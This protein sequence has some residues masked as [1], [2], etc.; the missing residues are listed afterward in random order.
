MVLIPVASLHGQ[1]AIPAD[2]QTNRRER[3]DP[4]ATGMEQ[5]TYQQNSIAHC[6]QHSQMVAGKA[7]HRAG[8]PPDAAGQPENQLCH[9]GQRHCQNSGNSG[10]NAMEQRREKSAGK[11]NGNQPQHQQIGQR[12]I[13]GDKAEMDC[14]QGRGKQR[15]ANGSGQRS[16]DKFS[17]GRAQPVQS[18]AP[19]PQKCIAG[20]RSKQQS[21]HRG[22][23]E[24]QAHRT[25]R[26][27]IDQQQAHQRSQQRRGRVIF[28][29]DN[30]RQQQNRLHG[31]GANHRRRQAGHHGKERNGQYAEQTAFP[32]A[33]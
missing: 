4:N 5:N 10:Q 19:L 31:T 9:L 26:P 27:G 16:A 17:K 20:S 24:L 12:P 14:R 8:Q 32:Y 11:A 33:Q 6:H 18:P 3:S 2:A 21:R 15:C 25:H 13:H 30:R 1:Q 28:P 7:D 22:K 23:A 29:A